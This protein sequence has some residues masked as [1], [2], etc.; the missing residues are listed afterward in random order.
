M[1][2]AGMYK[3]ASRNNQRRAEMVSVRDV[4]AFTDDMSDEE[5]K[6]MLKARLVTLEETILWGKLKGM[7]LKRLG[8]E[9]FV[10]QTE[11]ARLKGGR[12]RPNLSAYF[13]ESAKRLLTKAQYDELWEDAKRVYDIHNKQTRN[14]P[15]PEQVYLQAERLGVEI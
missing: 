6:R 2:Q 5:R 15:L 7:E 13:I 3:N 8:K 4:V 10:V 1:G 11:L 12:K 14:D 9:K